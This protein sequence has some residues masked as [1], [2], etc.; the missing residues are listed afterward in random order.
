MA[1]D[2]HNL[3]EQ[4]IVEQDS[5]R[6]LELVQRL[7]KALDEDHEKPPKTLELDRKQANA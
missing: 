6:L 3:C 1:E 2:W 5:A 4:I 7:N